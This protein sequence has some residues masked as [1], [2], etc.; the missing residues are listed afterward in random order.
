MHMTATEGDSDSAIRVAAA[1]AAPDP[2][3]VNAED[4]SEI[5]AT[6][7]ELGLTIASM[8]D[9]AREET[10]SRQDAQ[11]TLVELHAIVEDLHAWTR[12]TFAVANPR[13]PLQK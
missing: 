13:R 1:T 4:V 10:W 6:L 11:R 8:S 12:R 5:I 7:A 9:A 2:H 3:V